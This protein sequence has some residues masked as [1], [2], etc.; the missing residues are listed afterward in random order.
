MGRILAIDY[1]QK[2]VG[3]AV[4]DESQLIATALATVHTKNLFLFLNDYLN[5][6]NVDFI[7]IGEARQMNYTISE[8]EKF[9]G[10]FIKKLKKFYPEMKVERFDERLTSKIA[11]RVILESGLKKT[12]RKNKALI[13]RISATLIL[14][15]Y[16]HFKSI[17]S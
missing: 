7:V 16:L 2:R 12:D 5:K 10:P 14:Q 15:S 4:T 13:D 3:L 11:S 1:G 6:E 17:K 8:S 9:T